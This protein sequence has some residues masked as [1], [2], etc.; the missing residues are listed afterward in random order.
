MDVAALFP[1][2]NQE[3]AA[4]IVRE[5]FEAADLEVEGIDWK[6]VALYFGVTASTL[7]KLQ[8]VQNSA[9]RL[10]IGRDG[11]TALDDFFLDAH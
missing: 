11:Q 6:G 8:H 3:K 1:S 2:I 9:A 4:K 7:K 5:K 10:I